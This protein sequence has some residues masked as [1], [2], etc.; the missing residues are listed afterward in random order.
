MQFESLACGVYISVY[1][2]LWGGLPPGHIIYARDFKGQVL[3]VGFY[4]R[5]ANTHTT[6][7]CQ[8]FKNYLTKTARVEGVT[9]FASYPV[10]DY[11][12]FES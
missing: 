3:R 5:L 7:H 4:G 2:L 8:A 9:L 6:Q 11:G 1:C 12:A 10:T